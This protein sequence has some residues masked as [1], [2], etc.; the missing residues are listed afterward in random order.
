LTSGLGY[1][2]WY[3]AVSEL[4]ASRAA[5]LQLAVPV[6]TA[7]M[8]VPLLDERPTLRLAGAA[9]LVLGGIGLTLQ[10]RERTPIPR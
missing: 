5:V 4:P 3:R 10:A 9:A 6:L 7:A 8:A 1:V 2:A